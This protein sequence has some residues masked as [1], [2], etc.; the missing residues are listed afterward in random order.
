MTCKYQHECVTFK[1]HRDCC[2]SDETRCMVASE[3]RRTSDIEA[4]D[5]EI[6]TLCGREPP[7]YFFVLEGGVLPTLRV[8]GDC[9]TSEGLNLIETDWNQVKKLME[10]GAE[11]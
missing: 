11:Q 3:Y 7:Q 8:C 6:C 9:K 10:R 2:P 1:D 5:E 4:L